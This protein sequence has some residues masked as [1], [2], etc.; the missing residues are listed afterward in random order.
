MQKLLTALLF[1]ALLVQPAM[2]Q[3]AAPAA[4]A[5]AP[6]ATQTETDEVAYGMNRPVQPVPVR[7]ITLPL[8]VLQGIGHQTAVFLNNV[9]DKTFL[10]IHD[11]DNDGE[12]HPVGSIARAVV[13][14]PAG[15]IGTVGAIG[16]G[17]VS[18]TVVGLHRGLTRGFDTKD[19][20]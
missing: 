20:D 8:S 13:M 6:A 7:I 4:D 18:G 14:V 1:T 17:V 15:T 12:N 16:A 19:L 11:P 9:S 2:A 5:Q 10:N 3:D